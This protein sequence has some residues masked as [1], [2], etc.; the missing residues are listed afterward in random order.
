MKYIPQ[1]M[2]LA[3]GMLA[4]LLVAGCH[5]EVKSD[6]DARLNAGQEDAAEASTDSGN[7]VDAGTDEQDSSVIQEPEPIPE[8]YNDFQGQNPEHE[9]QPPLYGPPSMLGGR[10]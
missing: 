8:E 7:G 10:D 9:I 2:K 1:W 3:S 4:S 5:A 6:A